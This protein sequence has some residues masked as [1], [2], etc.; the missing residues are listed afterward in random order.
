MWTGVP[1]N[2]RE[3]TT[4]GLFLEISHRYFDHPR[5]SPIDG[6]LGRKIW[7][8]TTKDSVGGVDNAEPQQK[9][10]THP[11]EPHFTR[12]NSTVGSVR[13][14]QRWSSTDPG[15]P[16]SLPSSG[17]T[18][19]PC[20]SRTSSQPNHPE[21]VITCSAGSANY[22]PVLHLLAIRAGAILKVRLS[23]IEQLREADVVPRCESLGELFLS[24][25]RDEC[26]A[27]G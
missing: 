15:G 10:D 16:Q 27:D 17:W 14:R 6:S 21:E 26:V 20:S 18:F 25:G 1:Q 8:R 13:E 11:L 12:S 9:S 5:P 7:Q 24:P 22:R 23:T 2:E 3:T 19:L 4:H